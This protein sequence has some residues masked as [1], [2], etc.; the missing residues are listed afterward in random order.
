MG[1]VWKSASELCNLA[2]YRRLN[3][4]LQLLRTLRDD[5]FDVIVGHEGHFDLDEIPR[6]GW[7][8]SNEFRDAFTNTD[9]DQRHQWII[10]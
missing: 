6:Y 2:Q 7:M 5:F 8:F 9:N 1:I 4:N 10:V 3:G